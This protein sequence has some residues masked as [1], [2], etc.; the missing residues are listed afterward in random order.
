MGIKL[1]TEKTNLKIQNVQEDLDVMELKRKFEKLF[2][3][4]KTIKG[5]QVDIKLIP[6][7]KLM[8]QKGRLIPIHLQPAV[9]EEMEK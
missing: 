7:A 1:E 8:Q 2:H 9:G 4:N 3:E 5:M 6:H